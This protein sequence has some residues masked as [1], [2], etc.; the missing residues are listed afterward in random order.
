[1]RRIGQRST[2][3]TTG[4]WLVLCAGLAAIVALELSEQLAPQVT[5]ALPA[6]PLPESA[7]EPEL[8]EPPPRHAFAEI[9]ARPLFSDSRRPFAVDSKPEEDTAVEKIAIE[10]VGTLVTEQSRAA[11]LQ[12]HGQNARWLRA[13]ESIGNW[14]VKAIESNQV[15]LSSAD[16]AKTVELR[17]DLVQPARPFKRVERRHGQGEAEPEESDEAQDREH[18]PDQAADGGIEDAERRFE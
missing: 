6:V 9:T 14:Q 18:E 1:M 2:H 13:G 12:P 5:A 11:L 3:W 4:L 10:L 8:F 16:E 7:P 17:A 15:R